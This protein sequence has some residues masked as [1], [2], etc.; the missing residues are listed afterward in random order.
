ML[1]TQSTLGF[2]MPK[3][4]HIDSSAHSGLSQTMPYGSHT[5]YLTA[6]FVEQWCQLNPT[7]QVIYRDVGVQPPVPITGEWIHAAFKPE[8]AREGWM[9]ETLTVSDVL[10]D[11]ILAADVIFTGVPTYNF[12]LVH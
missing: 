5:R 1:I 7:T 3:L 4:M 12:G 8:R 2:I 6:L 10:I 11:E 9:R